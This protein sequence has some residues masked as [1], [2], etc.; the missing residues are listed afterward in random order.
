M[1]E[2]CASLF[3]RLHQRPLLLAIQKA[4]VDAFEHCWQFIG[5]LDSDGRIALLI[6]QWWHKSVQ[7][8]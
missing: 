3:R 1:T 7:R 5:F 6:I 2:G 4:S 8:L